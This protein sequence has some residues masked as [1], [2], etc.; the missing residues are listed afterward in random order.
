MTIPRVSIALTTYNGGRYL[1]E[2]LDSVLGQTLSPFEIVAV[3]D[4]STD[5]TVKILAEYAQRGP[6]RVFENE[7]NLGFVK[8]FEKAIRLCEGDVIALCDQD[9]IW[10]AD[11]LETQIAALEG[12][13]L[14]YSDARLMDSEGRDLEQSI[15]DLHNLRFVS[16]Q[17]SRKM[18]LYECMSGNTMMFR[19]DLR[20]HFLPIPAEFPFHDIWIAFV[21]ASLG[22]L[23]VVETSLVRYRRHD[24]NITRKQGHAPPTVLRYGLRWAHD[25]S[26]IRKRLAHLAA[27][28]VVRKEDLPLLRELAQRFEH[29]R[30]RWFDLRLFLL[31]WRNRRDFY[32]I[33]EPPRVLP[34]AL[35]LASGFPTLR[36]RLRLR[37]CL[38]R[39]GIGTR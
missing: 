21:A 15:R 13:Q 2:Q 22:T 39:L 20:Q 19:T 35:G 24:A 28:P 12:H 38:W 6:V 32:A 37:S 27:C 25:R 34:R 11:K 3:D 16:G 33:K 29:V 4:G 9:D 1:R 30:E 31:L 5:D 17:V 7:T 23:G 10:E 26:R 8:N 36:W 18:F 14:V